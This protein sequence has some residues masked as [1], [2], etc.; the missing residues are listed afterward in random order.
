[1]SKIIEDYIKELN[2][3]LEDLPESD[4]QDVIDYYYEF[5]LDGDFQTEQAIIEDLGTPKMLARKVLADY[6][7]SA[8][9][10]STKQSRKSS[11]SNLKTIWL[12]LLGVLAAPIGIPLAIVFAFVMIAVLVIFCAVFIAF[13]A[14]VLAL[15]TGGIFV[16]VKTFGLL[17]SS[18]W[19]TGMFYVGLSLALTTIGIMLLPIIGKFVQF[20]LARCATLFR[21]LGGK[22]FKRHYFKTRST[23]GI[24][25]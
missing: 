22:I 18:N 10:Q 11:H 15:I 16:L 21:Y 14:F 12:I 25:E 5:L 6:S 4:R 19:A 7:A 2:Q 1:M 17:C 24:E 23:S 3:K 13:V 9:S 20:L 8:D